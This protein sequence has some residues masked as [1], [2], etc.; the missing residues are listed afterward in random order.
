LDKHTNLFGL[1]VGSE[2]LK[3]YNIG[4]RSG[5]CWGP[6]AQRIYSCKCWTERGT[7]LLFGYRQNR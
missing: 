4:L 5:N 1:H 2:E 6:N 7:Q 3:F